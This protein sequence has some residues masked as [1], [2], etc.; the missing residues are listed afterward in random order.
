MNLEEEQ[1]Q[2]VRKTLVEYQYVFALTDEQLG[3]TEVVK[4]EI[5]TGTAKQIKERSRRLP[6]YAIDEVDRQVDGMLKRG[7]IEHSNSPWAAGVVLVGKKDNTLNFA[8]FI[9]LWTPLL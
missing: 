6:H 1:I 4:H 2:S 5:N 8:W 7:I 3:R 9:G